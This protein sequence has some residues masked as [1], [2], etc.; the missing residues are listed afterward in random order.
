M[1][2]KGGRS[3]APSLPLALH[4]CL[5]FIFR[6]NTVSPGRAYDARASATVPN[7]E[8]HHMNDPSPQGSQ[9]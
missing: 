9:G 7:S 5:P 8:P 4:Q 6:G 3:E 2:E 1:K